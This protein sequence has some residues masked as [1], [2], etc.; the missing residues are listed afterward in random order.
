[1]RT[2]GRTDGNHR[3]IVSGL[4]QA[5]CSVQSLAS[6]GSGCP[7]LLV[8]IRGVNYLFEVK[9]GSKSPSE[10][11]LTD[12]ELDWINNWRGQVSVIGNLET[13]LQIMKIL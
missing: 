8:S 4:R 5:G 13:A 2:R 6:V 11:K 7:D 1:M 12:D 9:D 10:R 3:S